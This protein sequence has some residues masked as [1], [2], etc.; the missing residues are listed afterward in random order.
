MPLKKVLA[1]ISA[2]MLVFSSV[3]KSLFYKSNPSAY[4]FLLSISAGQII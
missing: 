2:E 3:L 1:L 4:N